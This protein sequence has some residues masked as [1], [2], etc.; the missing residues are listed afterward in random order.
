M[1]ELT[2]ATQLTASALQTTCA[3]RQNGL[4]SCWG[5]GDIGLLGDGSGQNRLSPQVVPD[6]TGV[7]SVAPGLEHA[8]AILDD[9][10]VRCWGENS[11]G[12]PSP[13]TCAPST[14]SPR[15]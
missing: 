12:E 10:G 5:R 3:R 2:D 6:L 8:C 4:V 13:N 11:N 15:T 9:Q 7:A 1:P 14:A